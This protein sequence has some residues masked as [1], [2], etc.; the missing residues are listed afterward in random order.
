MNIKEFKQVTLELDDKS[1]YEAYLAE[2][3]SIQKN[4]L[5]AVLTYK[6]QTRQQ[7]LIKSDEFII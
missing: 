1:V 5:K 6:I 4:F 3:D 7:G 2:E